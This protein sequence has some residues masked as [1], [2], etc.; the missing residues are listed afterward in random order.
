M[1]AMTARSPQEVFQHH[2]EALMAENLDGMYSEQR[3]GGV[4]RV[5]RH[6][7]PDRRLCAMV[8]G[9]RA[10]SSC[11][12]PGEVLRSSR[13]RPGFRIRPIRTFTLGYLVKL[14]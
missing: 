9:L 1:E 7:G 14:S 6:S 12:R 3:P 11:G 10:L 5:S 8:T 4:P 2:G 13:W